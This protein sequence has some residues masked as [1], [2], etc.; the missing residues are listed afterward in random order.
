M[1]KSSEPTP[2]WL[3]RKEKQMKKKK[4]L[5]KTAQGGRKWEA[6]V[7]LGRTLLLFA[8]AVQEEVVETPMHSRLT[9]S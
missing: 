9:A 5:G 6:M 8:T 4:A 2:F 1:A 3:G 7:R